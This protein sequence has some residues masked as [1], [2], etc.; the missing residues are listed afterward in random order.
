MNVC[1]G[2]RAGRTFE[3]EREGDYIRMLKRERARNLADAVIAI[4]MGVLCLTMRGELLKY[5]IAVIGV[6]LVAAGVID[7]V[8]RHEIMIGVVK[9]VIGVFAVSMA[10]DPVTV[11]ILLYL[12]AVVM[13]FY[14]ILGILQVIS[15]SSNGIKS[16]FHAAVRPAIHLAIGF[17][18]FFHQPGFV[19]WFFI[20]MGVLLIVI[21][22]LS[23]AAAFSED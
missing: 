5:M 12:L 20:I 7:I 18:L 8:L 11:E 15:N 21:G 4:G 23:V 2:D 13:T 6:L 17:A 16:K 3:Q 22:V 14:G 10:W 9:I 19:S 1:A